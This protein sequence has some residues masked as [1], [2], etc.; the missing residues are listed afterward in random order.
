MPYT[1][2]VYV[3]LIC[4]PDVYALY[5]CLVCMPEARTSLNATLTYQNAKQ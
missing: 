3:C 2:A 5:V 1:Y 4:M